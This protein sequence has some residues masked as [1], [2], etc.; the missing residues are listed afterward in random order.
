MRVDRSVQ[1]AVPF[2]QDSRSTPVMER[3]VDGE[4]GR[5]KSMQNAVKVPFVL[6]CTGTKVK[7]IGNDAA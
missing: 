7:L 5:R 2:Q 1:P 4:I 3:G 6:N